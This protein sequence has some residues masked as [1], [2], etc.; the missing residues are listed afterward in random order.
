MRLTEISYDGPMPIDSYG[1]GFFRVEGEVVK[2]PIL[3]LPGRCD[4]WGGFADAAAIIANAAQFDV[5]FVGVG[6]EIAMLPKDFRDQ[7]TS[8]DVAVEVMATPAASRTYNVLLS[9]GR[10]IAAALIPV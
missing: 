8:A 6:A 4:A 7:L 1:P 2:G 10:R 9:E 5:L 3:M